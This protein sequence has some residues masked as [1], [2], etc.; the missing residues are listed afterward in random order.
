MLPH[1]WQIPDIFFIALDKITRIHEAKS[2]T[3]LKV[4][5]ATFFVYK[6]ERY[7]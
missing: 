1:N 7:F 5:K 4:N 2:V 3:I 6:T